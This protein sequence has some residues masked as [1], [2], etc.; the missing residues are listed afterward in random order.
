MHEKL[1]QTYLFKAL[2]LSS[3]SKSEILRCQIERIKGQMNVK[4]AY[5]N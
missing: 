2:L 5:P 1:R 3:M 4:Q